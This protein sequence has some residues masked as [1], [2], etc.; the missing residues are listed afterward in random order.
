MDDYVD[1][2]ERTVAELE[3]DGIVLPNKVLAM[4]LIDSAKLTDK[5]SQIILTGVNYE[6]DIEMYEQS[7][8]TLRKL[9]REQVVSHSTVM[10][11]DLNAVEEAHY[12]TYRGRCQ[13][14]EAKCTGR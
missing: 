12:T 10:R 8:R 6:E 5:E 3:R 13:S 9:F 11:E 2:F 4:Q 14:G 1:I 7:K